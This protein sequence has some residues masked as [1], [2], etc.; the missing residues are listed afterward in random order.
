M[1]KIKNIN[2]EEDQIPSLKKDLNK[3]DDEIKLIKAKIEELM[4]TETQGILG[5]FLVMEC[6]QKSLNIK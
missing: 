5:K 6:L 3:Y 1:Q 2:K 4:N